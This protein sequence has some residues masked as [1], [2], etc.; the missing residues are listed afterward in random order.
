M[1]VIWQDDK[2]LYLAWFHDRNFLDDSDKFCNHA[3]IVKNNSSLVSY[4]CKKPK[5]SGDSESTVFHVKN[6]YMIIDNDLTLS[7]KHS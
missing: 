7:P 6:Y 2:R 1:N 5:R 3:L 4:Q